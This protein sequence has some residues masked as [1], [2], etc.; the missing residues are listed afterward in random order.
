MAHQTQV[1]HDELCDKIIV[2]PRLRSIRRKTPHCSRCPVREHGQF[3][4]KARLIEWCQE[5][6]AIG[7]TP[8]EKTIREAIKKYGLDEIGVMGERGSSL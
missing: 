7:K 6:A 8:D 4:V 5:N 3:P 2:A 1:T